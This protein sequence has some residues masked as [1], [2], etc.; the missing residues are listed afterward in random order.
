MSQTRT[1]QLNLTDTNQVDA[2]VL[3]MATRYAMLTGR[4]PKVP[5]KQAE[6]MLEALAL[7]ELF[8]SLFPEAGT[9]DT[10]AQTLTERTEAAVDDDQAEIPKLK[11]KK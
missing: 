3:A 6:K 8:G 1:I 7:Y 5:R 10:V 4:R 2:L 9:L 11:S